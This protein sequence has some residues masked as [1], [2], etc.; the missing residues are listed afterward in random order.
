MNYKMTVTIA[1]TKTPAGMCSDLTMNLKC[2]FVYNPQQYGNGY[3]VSITEEGHE[4]AYLGE[5]YDLRYDKTFDRNHK[6]QWLEEWAKSYWSGK[7]GAYA[8]KAL[9][10]VKEVSE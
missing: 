4:D 1:G 6:E 8:V 7:D 10:I 2:R 9:K 5:S 3:F